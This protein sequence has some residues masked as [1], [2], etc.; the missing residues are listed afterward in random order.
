MAKYVTVQHFS[1]LYDI[2]ETNIHVL[3]HNHNPEWIMKIN[4]RTCI[5][6]DYLI[7]HQRYAKKIWLSAHDYYYYFTHVLQLKQY[8]L[9]KVIA[10]FFEENRE[11]W[12]EYMRNGLFKTIEKSMISTNIPKQLLKFVEFSEIFIKKLHVRLR[13]QKKYQDY[14][15]DMI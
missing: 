1:K 9:A 11:S 3:R 14:L 2:P 13:K 10:E 15:G 7:D 12:N 8:F 4:G 6:E 5:D